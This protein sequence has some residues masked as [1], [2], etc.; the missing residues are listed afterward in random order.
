MEAMRGWPGGTVSEFVHP[1]SEAQG[2]PVQIP[3]VDLYTLLVKPC[4]GRCPT[5]KVEKDGHGC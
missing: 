1:A 5:Y 4:C 3:V 2:L